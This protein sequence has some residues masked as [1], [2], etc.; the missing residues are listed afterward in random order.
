MMRKAVL[1]GVM[2]HDSTETDYSMEELEGLARACEMEVVGRVIQNLQKV[3]NALYIGRGKAEEVGELARRTEAECVVFDNALT[4]TQYRNLQDVLEISVLDRTNLILEIFGRR[5]RTREARLQV[6]LAA[7][8]YMLPRLVGMRKELSRQG[9]GTGAGG[10]AGAGGG[11][12]NRGGGEK[13]L[14]LDRRRIEKRISEI[15]RELEEIEQGRQTRRKR[16]EG[17]ELPSV[18]LVGYTNAGK[19]TLMNLMLDACGA[20]EEKKVMAQDML[21]ATLDTTVR[22]ISVGDHRDFL[23]SDTVGFINKLP[24]SLVK[25]FRSTLAEAC[26]ADLLLYVTDV[27]DAHHRE[28]LQVTES[29][30]HELE[31]DHIPCIYVMNK[32]DLVMDPGKLPKV[33][34]DKV[35][36]SA[37]LGIGFEELLGLI[38]EKLFSGLVDCRMR[39]PYTDG[40]AVSWLKENGLVK[41]LEYVPEGV[42]MEV[43]CQKSAAG[44]FREYLISG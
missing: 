39:I 14:E 30:L 33:R 8:Q 19:S 36:M 40:A 38:R 43:Q 27:S 42:L 5:A 31:A 3:N 44:R 32:A 15:R 2:L 22:R 23:L 10:G 25:A 41:S 17:S 16:R 24:H 35:Y 11:L 21:F 1:V 13:K 26:G 29:T 6:E 28:H 9:G 4:P 20:G 34:G 7:R 37:G 12:V 18:A